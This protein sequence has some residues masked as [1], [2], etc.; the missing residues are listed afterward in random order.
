[1]DVINVFVSLDII[2]LSSFFKVSELVI[3]VPGL[4]TNNSS[5]RIYYDFQKFF[6]KNGN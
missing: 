5:H 2:R 1:M 3:G 6:P 4:A